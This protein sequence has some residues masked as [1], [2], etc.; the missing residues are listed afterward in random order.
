MYDLVSR[1]ASISNCCNGVYGPNRL[2]Y[3]KLGHNRTINDSKDANLAKDLKG[4]PHIC[5][6]WLTR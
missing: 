1:S 2:P 4:K 5:Q 6:H 3:D